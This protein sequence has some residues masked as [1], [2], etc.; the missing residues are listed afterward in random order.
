MM[1]FSSKLPGATLGSPFVPFESV[2]PTIVLLDDTLF[3]QPGERSI[4]PMR[5][6]LE[7]GS[8]EGLAR[9]LPSGEKPVGTPFEKVH[10]SQFLVSHNLF[11]KKTPAART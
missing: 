6:L 8:F 5:V 7:S 4:S 11:R 3:C 9:D 2:M 1:Q 10:D